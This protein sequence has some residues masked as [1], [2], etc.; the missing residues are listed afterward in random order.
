MSANQTSVPSEKIL[1]YYLAI[2]SLIFL[3]GAEA[4]LLLVA[5]IYLYKVYGK[6]KLVI[7]GLVINFIYFAW[8]LFHVYQAGATFV[9]GIIR[10]Y[11]GF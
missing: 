3:R 1:V 7:L 6:H 10:G 9:K 5:G 11:N 4:I 8:F 2:S